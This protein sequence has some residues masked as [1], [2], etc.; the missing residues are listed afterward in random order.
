M[1][2]LQHGP[3]ASLSL[4]LNRIGAVQPSTFY[5]S[6]HVVYDEAESV[7]MAAKTDL[8]R[9][10]QQCPEEEEDEQNVGMKSQR[11]QE[12]CV[13]QCRCTVPC[14]CASADLPL[15]VCLRLSLVPAEWLSAYHASHPSVAALQTQVDR[16]MEGFD[17]RTA[18]EKAAA[19]SGGPTVDAEG[20]TMVKST[21]RNTKRNLLAREEETARAAETA[22]K[23]ARKNT[24]VHFYK[25]QEREIKKE[26][27]VQLREKFEQD[28][29]KIA[30][31]KADR[32]FKP[33]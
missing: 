23:K 12:H 14:G 11:K 20:W 16:F 8:S 26:R 10:P 22:A 31:M 2:F 18:A 4:D 17:A 1:H 21:G 19:R 33:Y 30:K 7:D 24:V 5:R 6:A 29:I 32:K 3:A 15:S 27:L 13:A 9:M 25:H 28:K